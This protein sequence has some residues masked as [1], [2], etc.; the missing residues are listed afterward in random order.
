MGSL[1]GIVFD[2]DDTLVNSTAAMHAAITA[3][4]PLLPGTTP[5]VLAGALKQGY[6]NLWGYPGDGYQ[7]LK[8]LL[9]HELRHALTVEALRL[10]GYSNHSLIAAV[11][12]RYQTTEDALLK[13]LPGAIPLLT[14]L[15]EDF[16]LGIIT[17][18]PSLFQRAKLAQ[19]GLDSF[20]EMVVADVDFGAPKPDPALFAY[21]AELLELESGELLFAGDSIEAD[22]AGANAAG[23]SCVYIGSAP[24]EEATYSLRA[25]EEILTLEPVREVQMRKRLASEPKVAD[26]RVTSAG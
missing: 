19:V 7:Q 6:H 24:C 17:N 20:F 16:R 12:E 8:T 2:L 11:R 21:A 14:A 22:I 18:G 15:R 4:L 9:P 25:L 10:L 23:W 26:T 3:T 13:P 5:L 1:K